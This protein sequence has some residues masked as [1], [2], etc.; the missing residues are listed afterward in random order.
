[1]IKNA[2]YLVGNQTISLSTCLRLIASKGVTTALETEVHPVLHRVCGDEEI[3]Y[4]LVLK[5]SYTEPE[6]ALSCGLTSPPMPDDFLG[7]LPA[8]GGS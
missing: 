1:M 5:Y 8:Y 3:E 6:V 2:A 4:R 7:D